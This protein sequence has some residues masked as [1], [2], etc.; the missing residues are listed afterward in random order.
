MGFPL[1]I[2]RQLDELNIIDK[3]EAFHAIKV[4]RLKQGDRILITNGKG[5]MVLAMIQ[6]LEKYQFYFEIEKELDIE[7]LPYNL[8]LAVAPTKNMDRDDFM[9]EK[10]TE[11]GL[12]Q[13]TPIFC[14][15]SER[16]I[17]KKDR[18]DR[19]VIAAVK[20]SLKATLPVINEPQTFE[21]FVY[22][23]MNISN[24]YI[25]LCSEIE[26]TAIIEIAKNTKDAIV[27]IGPEGDFST[28]EIKMAIN[29]GFQPI[30]LGHSRLRTETAGIAVCHTF[31]VVN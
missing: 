9:V 25:A 24:K 29:N 21:K 22:D 30:S 1:F 16:R 6:K 27:V 7:P 18:L 2:H 10:C 17:V 11:M 14:E 8:H 3:E 28:N 15:Q 20:Q 19:I 5:K 23:N 31:Y 4:L 12:S 13:L 26:K